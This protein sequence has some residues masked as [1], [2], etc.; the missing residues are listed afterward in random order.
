M[1]D[2]T[3]IYG[4]PIKDA[5]ARQDIATN[6]QDITDLKSE[7]ILEELHNKIDEMLKNQRKLL[8]KIEE[9]E[10]SNINK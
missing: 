8:K 7:L 10:E 6:T 5:V 3:S 9:S 4:N 2:I 1:A